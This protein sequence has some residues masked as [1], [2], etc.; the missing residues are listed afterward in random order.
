MTAITMAVQA[1]ATY[2]T[3]TLEDTT[4]TEPLQIPVVPAELAAAVPPQE[5][6][7]ST[8]SSAPDHF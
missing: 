2:L 6:A 7:V 3:T 5:D 8:R 4:A 1:K